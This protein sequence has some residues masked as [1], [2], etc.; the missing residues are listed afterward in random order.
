[1]AFNADGELFVYDAD[2]EW[3]FG[4]PWYR[5]DARHPR[6][7]RQRVRLAERHRQVAGVLRRQPAADGRHRPRL[8]GR[9]RPSATARSS[10]RS[11]R[12]PCYICDWTFGTMYAIHLE[13]DGVDLQG[14]EGR[15][16]L[17]HAAAADRRRASAPTARCTSRSAAAGTQS[18][19]FRVTYVGNESTAPVDDHDTA[20]SPT[21]GAPA[22]DR[23]SITARADD[24][25]EGD[26]VR[27]SVP[28]PRRPLHPLRRAG[29]PGAPGR[30][31]LAGARA[32]RARPEAL[33]TGAV[34]LARQG[35]KSLQPKLLA[36]L[37]RLD[38]S[39]LER[40]PAARTAP[41]LVSSS[42]SGWASPTPRRRRAGEEARRP[43]PRRER[44]VN[45]ELADLLVYLKSPDDRRASCIA[46]MEQATRGDRGADDPELLARNPG[47]GGTIAKM[48][49]NRPDA[50]EHPLRV[51]A[52]EPARRAGRSTSASPTSAGSTRPG[53]GPAAQLPG[54]H[55]QH[56]QGRLRERHRRRAPGHRGR[57]AAQA[58]PGQGT[59]QAQGPGP[60]LDARRAARRSRRASCTGRNF[61]NGQKAF[62]AARC[63]LCHRF[64]GEGGATG[65]DLTQAAGRFGFKD[66]AEAIVDPSK[67]VSDQ[68]RASIVATDSGKVYTGRIVGETTDK[69]TILVDPEDSTKV[70]EIPKSEIEEIEPSPS[71][72]DAREAA[73]AAEPERGARP[74]RLP[75][76]AQLM[77]HPLFAPAVKKN[78]KVAKAK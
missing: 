68:Y 64:A 49:A 70:V 11:I 29:R 12:R 56:R 38:F 71:L 27:L 77:K 14:G 37:D 74:A 41:G 1:M 63:V 6:H 39:Q 23:S 42:S 34:G 43:L 7:Q 59:A 53:S 60:R 17:A 30:Q 25:A 16:R 32:R 75:A 13:P 61:E 76:L 33:I 62:A 52:P 36:A 54:L 58:V 45:R 22:R 4:M 73:Q 20:G 57:R 78:G 19:L 51:R 3:D 69:L 15:V 35:D 10:P 47:Y 8:A 5:P 21:C 24:P 40:V 55:Q 28:R 18:E 65:P 44:S 66:L 46:L 31:A 2:M 67:V 72:A 26:R 50:A 9:R 48:L